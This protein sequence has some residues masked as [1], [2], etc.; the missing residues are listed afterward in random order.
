MARPIAKHEHKW[1]MGFIAF[2]AIM[3]IT[4]GQPVTLLVVA[5]SL[6]G[7]ILPITLGTMLLA[8]RNKNIVGDYKHP[9]WLLLLGVV[10]VLVTL[11]LGI[12][13]LSGL[14]ALFS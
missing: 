7:L 8:A 9:N 1:I 11:F 13:S 10:V 6:N 2:S 14:M 5:G 4:I 12:R 3:F